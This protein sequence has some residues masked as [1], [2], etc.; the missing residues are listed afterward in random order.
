MKCGNG[1]AQVH[2]RPAPA[3]RRRRFLPTTPTVFPWSEGD[4]RRGRSVCEAARSV[5]QQP[6]YGPAPKGRGL[7]APW[8]QSRLGKPQ[9]LGQERYSVGVLVDEFGCAQPL[10]VARVGLYSQ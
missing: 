10:A 4:R 7:L 9:L 1:A 8:P 5:A 2:A 3:S 6:A